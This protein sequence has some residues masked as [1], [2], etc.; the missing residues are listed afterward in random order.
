MSDVD[1]GVRPAIGGRSAL[2]DSLA[3]V[4]PARFLV[5]DAQDRGPLAAIRCLHAS[6]SEVSATASSRVA[7][8]L[9]SRACG[10][11]AVVP[12]PAADVDAF[13]SQL[14]TVVRRTPHDLLI[15]GTDESLYAI[16]LRRDRLAP[17]VALGLPDH[18]IVDR[19]MDKTRLSA[20]ATKAG[21]S[22]PAQRICESFEEALDAAHGFGFPLFVKGVR[23]VTASDRGLIRYPTLAA[24]DEVA[25][26]EAQ[27]RYGRC[28]VQRCE[29]G[30]TISFAGVATP[31]GLLGSAV[32]RYRRTWPAPA[33]S[34]SFSETVA[35]SA[36]LRESVQTLVRAIGWVGLFELELI[37]REDGT[38]MAIDFNP[39][40]YGSMSIAR[41][42]GAPLVTLWGAWVL[43][44]DP[45]PVTA[46]PGV[47]Y[48]ME[49]MDARH[50]L[51]RMRAGDYRSAALAALP[52]R[53][54][55]HAYFRTRDP[56]PL[57]GR[58]LELARTRWRRRRA[59]DPALTAPGVGADAASAPPSPQLMEGL[60]DPS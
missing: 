31:R 28:I 9:W 54:V 14:V 41:A 18:E 59:R 19:A 3:S 52:R 20:E 29:A 56:L 24:A 17:H 16:S 10:R 47:R 27:R 2:R 58:G 48:R 26:G 34:A 46:R 22:T 40:L 51:W 55:T 6:G 53:R 36:A 32:S 13:V 44:E 23:T 5:T 7:P 60:L 49:D 50:I 43:G 8:G 42:A 37:E 15:P 38:T 4:T 39:R 25:L 1:H 12:N 33:G 11:R 21:L 30:R 45:R 35:P 57:V